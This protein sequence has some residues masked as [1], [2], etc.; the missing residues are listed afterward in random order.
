[1]NVNS[2][3]APRQVSILNIFKDQIKT[4]DIVILKRKGCSVNEV[5]VT[6]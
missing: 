3:E 6:V 1:M 2:S 5:S 4:E